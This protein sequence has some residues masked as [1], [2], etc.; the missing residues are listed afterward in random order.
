MKEFL[1]VWARKQTNKRKRILGGFPQ[2]V[3]DP[4]V[5]TGGRARRRVPRGRGRGSAVLAGPGPPPVPTGASLSALTWP[6][7]LATSPGTPTFPATQQQRVT[8]LLAG[9]SEPNRAEPGRAGPNRAHLAE[10]LAE[11]ALGVEDLLPHRAQLL[12]VCPQPDNSRA[13]EVARARPANQRRPRAEAE[14]HFR[15]SQ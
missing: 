11:D 13:P 1:R 4:A 9:P 14:R 2:K 6:T 10:P 8:K 12:H 3:P 5:G 15:S 7:I